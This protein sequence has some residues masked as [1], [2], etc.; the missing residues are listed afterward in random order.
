VE[1]REGKRTIPMTQGSDP[2]KEEM[3]RWPKH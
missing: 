3:W 2:W 1:R